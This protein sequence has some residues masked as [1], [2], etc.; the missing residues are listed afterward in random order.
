MAK[1]WKD[2]LEVGRGDGKKN[3]NTKGFGKSSA[4]WRCG[5]SITDY[6]F[7]SAKLQDLAGFR[8]HVEVRMREH[9]S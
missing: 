8:V 5:I 2:S 7:S 1:T 9:L 4:R 6:C 3:Q